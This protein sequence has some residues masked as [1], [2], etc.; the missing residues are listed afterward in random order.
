M[1]LG[2]L[3]QTNA[4]NIQILPSIRA[5]S[6][7]IQLPVIHLIH[8]YIAETNHGIFYLVLAPVFILVSGRFL[9]SADRALDRL[10]RQG[11][12]R[13][14]QTRERIRDV[15]AQRNRALFKWLPSACHCSAS[16]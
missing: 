10:E 7:W 5:A 3:A 12:I 1:I 9:D 11:R 13:S 14:R 6:G 4:L 16:P 8:G 15:V 2:H